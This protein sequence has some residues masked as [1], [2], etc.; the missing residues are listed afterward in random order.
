MASPPRM[1]SVGQVISAIHELF[2]STNTIDI[3]LSFTPFIHT[4]RATTIQAS[5]KV[6]CPLM[7]P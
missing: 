5:R 1:R 7:R 4:L 2:S 3:A 6:I